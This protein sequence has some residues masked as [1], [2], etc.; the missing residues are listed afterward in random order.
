MNAQLAQARADA[1]TLVATAEAEA[2]EA[3]QLV[4]AL[5][6]KVRAGD[7]TV[8]PEQIATA[9]ELGEFARLRADAAAR[10]A[11][12]AQA[13][14]RTAALLEL[15][16]EL[17]THQQDRGTRYAAHL[18]TAED[19]IRAY[20]DEVA[21]DNE[22]IRQ[23]Q[24]RM[25]DLDVPEHTTHHTPPDEH[26]GLGYSSQGLNAH[27]LIAGE[28]RIRRTNAEQWLCTMLARIVHD[29]RGLTHLPKATAGVGNGARLYEQLR[30]VGQ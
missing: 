28:Q 22:Q 15:R 20:L 6:E 19:A 1:E 12:H 9:R 13:S 7:D 21:S 29:T 23:W 25:R 8:S 18:K 5:Q 16:A 14:A 24:Q 10:K 26:A 4:D 11:E 27:C 17:D 3:R 30:K 2:R